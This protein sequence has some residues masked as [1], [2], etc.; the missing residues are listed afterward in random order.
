MPA[1]ASRSM[2]ILHFFIIVLCIMLFLSSCVFGRMN[3]RSEESINKVQGNELISAIKTYEMNYGFPPTELKNLIPDYVDSIPS[4][5]SGKPFEYHP[6]D[7]F[8]YS[9]WSLTFQN[10]DRSGCSYISHFDF[11]DC[12]PTMAGD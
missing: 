3:S 2:R 5:Y 8:A 10:R 7:N 11:W 12:W 1:Y 9:E 6:D 4:T